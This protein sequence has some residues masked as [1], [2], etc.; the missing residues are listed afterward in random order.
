MKKLFI[1]IIVL[2]ALMAAIPAIISIPKADI[3]SLFIKA[4]SNAD[5]TAEKTKQT[6][7]D[8]KHSKTEKDGFLL[9][10]ENGDKTSYS[11]LEMLCGALAAKMPQEYS[12][13][14]AYA[15]AAA[16][17]SQLCYMKENRS[18]NGLDG[19]DLAKKD[20][21]GCNFLTKQEAA[22]KYGGD[23]Y[24][25]CKKYAEHGI[26]TSITNDK[27]RI[28]ALV[29]RSCN[30]STNS[31]TELFPKKKLSYCQIAPSPWDKYG[32]I[33]SEK[34]FSREKTETLI[35]EKLKITKFPDKLSD[36]IKIKSTAQNG[37]VLDAELCGKAVSGID[38]MNLFSLK[39]PCFEI[40]YGEK[41]IHFTVIGEGI[42]VG[43]SIS[44]A[45]GMARQGAQMS[46]ILS[47][48]YTDCEIKSN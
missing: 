41:Q 40:E 17:Y 4:Q 46:E 8:D 10:E 45:D 31:A 11:Q 28:N 21:G 29:F 12:E 9:L 1:G 20:N 3:S 23:F 48:Y 33:Y 38:I 32:N 24:E 19:A 5:N 42:P 47:H 43:M 13:E 22:E 25:L 37:T 18:S 15:L 30:G 26:K 36:Y 14:S 6:H 2:F 39:S 44:G 35:T 34:N 16:L 7:S 27:K